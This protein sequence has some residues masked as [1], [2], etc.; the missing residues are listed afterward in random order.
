MIGNISGT[1]LVMTAPHDD[2]LLDLPAA[3]GA[4]GL[5]A[6]LSVLCGDAG[7]SGWV[8]RD[9]YGAGGALTARAEPLRAALGLAAEEEVRPN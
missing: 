7:G 1:L 9:V 5:A 3:A 8:Y 2:C 4:R 6:G